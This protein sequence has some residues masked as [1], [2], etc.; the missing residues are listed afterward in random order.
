MSTEQ[1]V[2]TVASA[3]WPPRP[4]D[5]LQ[6]GAVGTAVALAA[7]LLILM[8]GRSAGADM[9]VGDPG[10][11]AQTVGVLPVVITTLVG[12]VVG[13]LLLL[14]VRSRGRRVW[15]TVALAGFVIG[16]GSV[17]AP[18]LMTAELATHVTLAAMHIMTSLVWFFAVRRVARD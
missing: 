6:T 2:A 1:A 14:L 11:S 15:N 13:T 10:E 7:N 8:V 9:V 12:F 5:V 17:A 16:I 4:D 3:A 18:L